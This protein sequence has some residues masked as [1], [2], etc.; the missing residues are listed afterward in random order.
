MLLGGYN[1]EDF[2]EYGCVKSLAPSAQKTSQ[3]GL[4]VT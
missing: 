2:L 1:K 3:L 4:V